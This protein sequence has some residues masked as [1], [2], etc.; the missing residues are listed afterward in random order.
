MGPNAIVGRKRNDERNLL[1]IFKKGLENGTEPNELKSMKRNERNSLPTIESTREVAKEEKINDYFNGEIVFGNE[2]VPQ[3]NNIY[4][5]RAMR[6]KK[7][8]SLLKSEIKSQK[9]LINSA[10]LI[11]DYVPIMQTKKINL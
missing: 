4:Q 9:T 7:T 11:D 6:K 3:T 5:L 2:K 1:Q 10:S 8:L